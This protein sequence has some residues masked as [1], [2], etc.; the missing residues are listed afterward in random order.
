MGEYWEIKNCRI[1]ESTGGYWEGSFSEVRKMRRLDEDE[2]E[3]VPYLV[4]LLK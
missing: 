3:E 2:L 1:K 4:E